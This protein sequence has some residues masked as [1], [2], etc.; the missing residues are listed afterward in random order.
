VTLDVT[1]DVGSGNSIAWE[2]A[3]LGD[4]WQTISASTTPAW[5]VEF[6]EGQYG[7]QL[8]VK[9][10]LNKGTGN[11]TIASVPKI[12]KYV[13]NVKNVVTVSDIYPM[14]INILKLGLQISTLTTANR[15]GYKNMMIDLFQTDAG[16]QTYSP[17]F[18][19]SSGVFTNTTVSPAYLTSTV[20]PADISTVR[21][22]IVVGDSSSAGIVY[23]VRRGN[24]TWA[25]VTPETVYSFQSG[26]P[27]YEL[28]VRALVPASGSITGWA[29]LYA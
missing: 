22:I 17:T 19:Y 20:E 5:T 3:S 15:F 6:P 27:T 4:N 8:R 23:E 7:S 29:Y 10:T 13:A 1:Q 26:T 24:G 11:N 28:Q 16:V 9:A 21:N 2:V 14:Q 25:E 12:Q 18:S